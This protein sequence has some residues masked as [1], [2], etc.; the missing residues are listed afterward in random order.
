[1]SSLRSHDDTWDIA[2]SVGSTA[3]MVAAARAG[4]T[5]RENP[6]IRDPYAAVLVAGAGT[7]FW[8]TLLDQD[9]AAKIAEV[10]DEAAKIFEHMGSYQ[11]VRTHFFDAYFT[12]AAEAGI[13]QIVILAAGLDS[14]AYRLEW[15]AGTTVFEIDQ[16]KVLEYKAETLAAHG[17]QPS[18]RRHEVAVDL[19]QDWPKALREAGFDDSQPTAW[20]AEGLLMYLPADAQDRLFEL[21]TELSAP[22]SRIAAETAGVS[23]GERREEMRERFERFA[24]Q[25]NMEQALNIQDLIYEDPDRADVAEWLG[26]NGWRAGGVHS[27]DEMRRLGRYVEIEHVDT[28][29]FSTFV[30]AEKL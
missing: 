23:A 19:R 4:E 25:F 5:E 9:V 1:M 16:P 17:A 29:A 24:A 15:P 14:R 30:T 2:T 18:A 6:L 10:D 11:A 22:G 12:E 21:V 13:R 28:R 26:A 3:V 27:L 7:G 8:E 20:L